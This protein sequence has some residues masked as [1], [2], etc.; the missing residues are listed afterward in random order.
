[1]IILGIMI[2][3][4]FFEISLAAFIWSLCWWQSQIRL[5]MSECDKY[6]ATFKSPIRRLRHYII[7]MPADEHVREIVQ[8]FVNEN[9]PH[10]M[11]LILY[12]LHFS[13]CSILILERLCDQHD[14]LRSYKLYLNIF[15]T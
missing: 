5:R 4:S 8:Y 6:L 3:N 10:I 12:Y 2:K 7:S 13:K 9:H 1:M 11:K 14:F 15:P